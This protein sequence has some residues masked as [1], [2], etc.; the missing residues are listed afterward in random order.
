MT[1]CRLNCVKFN[2]Y[3]SISKRIIGQQA[4]GD[5]NFCLNTVQKDQLY[6]ITLM[7]RI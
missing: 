7:K 5:Q 3:A 2:K 6:S 4:E 1:V